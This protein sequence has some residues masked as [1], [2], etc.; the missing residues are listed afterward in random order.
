MSDEQ[1][2][3]EGIY[4]G[5]TDKQT[6]VPMFGVPEEPWNIDASWEEG[7]F[8]AAQLVVEGVLDGR[9]RPAIEGIA[10][11]YLYRHYLELQLK[12]IVFHAR[13][14]KDSQTNATNEEI[15]DVKKTHS[16]GTLWALAKADCPAKLGREAWDSFDIAFVDA[17]IA[18]FDAVDP[19]P[20]D[21][22]RYHGKKFGVAAS[23]AASPVVNHLWIGFETLQRN[24]THVRDV[25]SAIDTFL[26]ETHGQNDEWKD[27]LNSF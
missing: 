27:I 19:N 24:M 14:L 25:L 18:E 12:F 17:C 26:F 5:W 11:V 1:P 4:C 23:A 15:E 9:R 22:F 6:Y 8:R 16:L 7:Y 21:R 2:E 10:G 13:W 20:G 3:E